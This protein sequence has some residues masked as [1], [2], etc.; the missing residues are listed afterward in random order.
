GKR[1]QDIRSSKSRI[2]FTNNKSCMKHFTLK[3]FVR[4]K[5]PWLIS[6]LVLFLCGTNYLAMG[7]GTNATL[8]GMVESDQGGALPGVSVEVKNEA[9]AERR[10]ASTNDKGLF[11]LP[12]LNAS[13]SYTIT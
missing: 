10:V 8:S 13:G 11:S 6:F 2:N 5:R 1:S 3:L 4:T 7:Q 9:N 12:N